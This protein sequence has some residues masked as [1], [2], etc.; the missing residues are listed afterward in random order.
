M[1]FFHCRSL[2][3]ILQKKKMFCS[4]LPLLNFLLPV[5][6]SSSSSQ[7]AH[8]AVSNSSKNLF[9]KKNKKRNHNIEACYS[10]VV[11]ALLVYRF[12][13]YS[14]CQFHPSV[15]LSLLVKF[16]SFKH[17]DKLFGFCCLFLFFYFCI[18]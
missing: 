6:L 16:V 13:Y 7:L 8:K 1:S 12:F 10:F 18:G 2:A 9:K 4:N 15:V 3:L 11:V 5:F 14:R 17:E